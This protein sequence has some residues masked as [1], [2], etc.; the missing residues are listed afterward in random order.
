MSRRR[1]GGSSLYLIAIA[2][3]ELNRQGNLLVTLPYTI[4]LLF[5]FG[6]NCYFV[7]HLLY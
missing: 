3:I 7:V 1:S 2:L 5:L 4:M 6:L